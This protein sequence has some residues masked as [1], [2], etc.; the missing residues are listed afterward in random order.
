M[1]IDERV[2]WIE[3]NLDKQSE[4]LEKVSSRTSSLETYFK[5]VLALAAVLGISGGF[6]FSQLSSV[7]DKIAKYE[8]DVGNLKA[9]I[10]Q[11]QSAANTLTNE[12]QVAKGD[13]L[14]AIGAIGKEQKEALTKVISSVTP[15]QLAGGVLKG[16][17]KD[18]QVKNCGGQS[19][20]CEYPWKKAKISGGNGDLNR[21]AKG[22]FIYI[23]VQYH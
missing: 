7:S 21:G 16:S 17:I 9:Q 8:T 20:E 4:N 2:V 11:M 18:L 10:E 19:C 13:A 3:R 1:S 5:V 6:I 14:R 22:D 23:C 15:E 12:V